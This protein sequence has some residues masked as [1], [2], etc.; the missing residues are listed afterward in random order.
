MVKRLATFGLV[1]L[2]AAL[3]CLPALAAGNP[4][5]RPSTWTSLVK[6]AHCSRALD[7]A[8][9]HGKMRSIDGSERMAMRFTLLERTGVEGFQPLAAPG[10]G[11]WRNSKPQVGAFG[12]KQIVRKLK[13]GAVYRVRVDYRWYDEHGAVV[14]RAHRR[15]A[16]C[17][18]QASLPN[19]RVRIT[20]ARHTQSTDTDRYWLKVTNVGRASAESVP[21]RF[22]VDGVVAG[23]MTAPTLYAGASRL[24]TIRAPDCENWV[25]AQVDP[26][27]A[28]AETVELDNTHQLACKDLRPR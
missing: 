1:A 3:A 20:G 15:S 18:N 27:G 23:T 4:G 24:I 8:V 9:F 28:I 11:K 6:V 17:P 2:F 21:V 10:L 14:S 19:L 16:T 7:E 12:Y 22:S 5:Y 13:K 25:Q 26:D